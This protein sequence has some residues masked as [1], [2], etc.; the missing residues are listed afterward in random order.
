MQLTVVTGLLALGMFWNSK[1][2]DDFLW[3]IELLYPLPGLLGT[4]LS[5]D[6]QK[7]S[8]KMGELFL[9]QVN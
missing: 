1:I 5:T 9:W 4:E 3:Y 7:F 6:A 8:V 2:Y